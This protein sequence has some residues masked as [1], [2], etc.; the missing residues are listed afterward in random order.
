MNPHPTTI[1]QSRHPTLGKAAKPLRRLKTALL[2]SSISLGLLSQ[3]T[4]AAYVQP[5]LPGS[6]ADKILQFNNG[7][8]GSV[9]APLPTFAF[10]LRY[11]STPSAATPGGGWTQTASGSVAYG[12]GISRIG[13]SQSQVAISANKMDFN[14]VTSGLANLAGA[15][16]PMTWK[17]TS[18]ITGSNT[19]ANL[20]SSY[21]YNFDVLLKDSLVNLSPAIFGSI[22]L[23]ITAGAN[24]LYQAT[25]LAQILGIASITNSSYTD[26]QV[27]FSYD[28][29]KGPLNITWSASSTI[30][31]SLL[32]ILGN[33]TNTMFEVKNTS[34]L[35]DPIPE[36]S[37]Y[38]MMAMGGAASLSILRRRRYA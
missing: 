17:A 32:G 7:A 15:S 28:Q 14:F 24:T 34:I 13:T 5:Y 19:W 10:G 23:Q 8:A 12:L 4:S 27:L 9:N 21:A 37:T 22:T 3:Y 35:V 6:T 1:N 30:S 11:S 33:G 20:G 2:C 26:Q 36:P 16:L 31:A 29:S 25:G 18:T 38:V